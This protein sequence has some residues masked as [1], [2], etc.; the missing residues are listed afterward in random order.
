M[1]IA[2]LINSVPATS[3]RDR[4][5]GLPR[6]E[7]LLAIYSGTYDFK[8][9]AI[10]PGGA[11]LKEDQTVE[12][13]EETSFILSDGTVSGLDYGDL[14]LD[15]SLVATDLQSPPHPAD[16][17]NCG[18]SAFPRVHIG[19]S[20][21]S[22]GPTSVSVSLSVGG[23][24]PSSAAVIS[25][26]GTTTGAYKTSGVCQNCKGCAADILLNDSS[27]DGLLYVQF[28]PSGTPRF[29]EALA[30]NG[31]AKAAPL[32]QVLDFDY[33]AVANATNGKYTIQKPYSTVHASQTITSSITVERDDD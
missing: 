14:K 26:K 6:R 16:K 29:H 19:P 25:Q 27:T 32:P 28:P 7:Y 24:V 3:H 10:Y 20:V 22:S 23:Y 4:S 11:Y 13:N 17:E 12:W 1:A 8:F 5:A 33:S 15:G 2:A 31:Y 21:S 9:E 30:P 18:Y